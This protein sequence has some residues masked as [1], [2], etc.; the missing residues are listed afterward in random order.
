[1]TITKQSSTIN[2]RSAPSPFLDHVEFALLWAGLVDHRCLSESG[3]LRPHFAS[4]VR[5]CGRAYAGT[6]LFACT[7]A[8][9]H[10]LPLVV[11]ASVP[12]SS[13]GFTLPLHGI[14][15]P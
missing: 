6:E 4:D 11:P 12:A 1:M 15:H 5:G 2:S 8:F 3:L 14:S 10:L 7:C 9:S 13:H